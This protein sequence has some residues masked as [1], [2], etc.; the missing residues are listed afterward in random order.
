MHNRNYAKLKLA[1][2]AADYQL[3]IIISYLMGLVNRKNVGAGQTAPKI[4]P[5]IFHPYS[6]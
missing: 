6:R 5:D 2:T 1:A 4:L 3:T